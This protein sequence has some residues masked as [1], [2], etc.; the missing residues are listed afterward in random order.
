MQGDISCLKE[1]HERFKAEMERKLLEQGIQIDEGF[2]LKYMP[3]KEIPLSKVPLQGGSPSGTAARAPPRRARTI[4][5][6][7]TEAQ[8]ERREQIARELV[9]QE[10]REAQEKAKPMK[11]R[12]RRKRSKKRPKAVEVKQAPQEDENPGGEDDSGRC[13]ICLDAERTHLIAPCGHRCLCEKCSEL[14]DAG[15]AC[16][17]CRAPCLLVFKVYD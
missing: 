3:E 5:V 15:E 10:E 14:V 12:A 4:A 2:W 6:E 13:V 17:I 16:P 9:E 7:E 1:S 8:R 11:P